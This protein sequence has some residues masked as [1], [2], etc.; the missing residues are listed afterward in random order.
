MQVIKAIYDGNVIR[1]IEPV[2]IKKNLEL[3]I[4]IP[5]EEADISPK[6]ARKLLRACAKGEGLTSKLLNSRRRDLLLVFPSNYK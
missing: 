2:K 6:D 3:F 1:L 5:D 4:I